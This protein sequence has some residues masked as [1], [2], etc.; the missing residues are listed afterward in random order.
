MFD[1]Y[2]RPAQCLS[3]AGAFLI[4]ELSSNFSVFC[5]P[6]KRGNRK[7]VGNLDYFSHEKISGT[8]RIPFYRKHE[9]K[10]WKDGNKCVNILFDKP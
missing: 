4:G 2:I 3:C 6:R 8:N 9:T 10:I 5:L 1:V 7:Y